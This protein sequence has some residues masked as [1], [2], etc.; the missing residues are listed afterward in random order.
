MGCTTHLQDIQTQRRQERLGHRHRR[1]NGRSP[2]SSDKEISVFW[3]YHIVIT[4][5]HSVIGFERDLDEGMEGYG[6][7]GKVSSYK[8]GNYTSG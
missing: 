7:A 4:L 1:T 3:N 6:L 5:F 2:S 8:Y